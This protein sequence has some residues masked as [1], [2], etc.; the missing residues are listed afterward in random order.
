MPVK[1][2]ILYI[3]LICTHIFAKRWI[4]Q[5]NFRIKRL[6]NRP[7]RELGEKIRSRKVSYG[8]CPILVGSVDSSLNFYPSVPSPFPPKGLILERID[9]GNAM[10]NGF[11][12]IF[13]SYER[14][15]HW[16]WKCGM[17]KSRSYFRYCVI[18]FVYDTYVICRMM[19][20]QSPLTYILKV[21]TSHHSISFWNLFVQRESR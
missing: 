18:K 8:T 12:C 15:S 10:Q 1:N 5:K 3:L 2:Y 19:N 13:G 6:A 7:G 16:R 4:I 20:S 14:I 11:L 17:R 21:F 9:L